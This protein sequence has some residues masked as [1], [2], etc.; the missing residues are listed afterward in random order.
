MR[1]LARARRRIPLYPRLSFPVR[2]HTEL[3]PMRGLARNLSEHGIL[4]QAS[5]LPPL[6]SRLEVGIEGSRLEDGPFFLL[7]DVRHHLHLAHGHVDRGR[8]WRAFGVRFLDVPG[9]FRRWPCGSL[10]HWH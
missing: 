5:D 7:G 3:G 2:L 9:R 4:I 8:G 6:G 1:R 10:P